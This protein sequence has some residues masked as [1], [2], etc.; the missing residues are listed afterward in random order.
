MSGYEK[1]DWSSAYAAPQGQGGYQ[2]PPHQPQQAWNQQPYAQQQGGY[3]PQQGGYQAASSPPGYG[4]PPPGRYDSPQPQQGYGAP[5]HP[6]G[7]YGAPP[8]GAPPPPQGQ[9]GAPPQQQWSGAPP[10]GPPGGGPARRHSVCFKFTGTKQTILNSQVLDPYGKMPFNV[11]SDKKHTTVRMADGSTLAKLQCKEW[12]KLDKS[13]KIRILHHAGQEYHWVTRDETVYL[14]P[15]DRPGSH[16]LIWRDPTGV[17][18]IEAFQESLI[19]PGLLEAAIVAVVIMQSNH[20]LG[21]QGGGGGSSTF[22]NALAGSLGASVAL[23]TI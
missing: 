13:K 18:E 19:V 8:Y 17:V 10:V 3:P 5:P 6:Q 22:I 16:I 14:E 9:Y 12:L 1:Q 21:E 4:A 15:A 20:K 7:Q 11:V 2:Q 23:G